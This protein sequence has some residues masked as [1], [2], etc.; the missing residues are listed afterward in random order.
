MIRRPPRST[1]TDTLFPYTTLFRSDPDLSAEPADHDYPWLRIATPEGCQQSQG[2][3]EVRGEHSALDHHV[4][5]RWRRL[6]PFDPGV[7]ESTQFVDAC[8]IDLETGRPCRPAEIGR[9]R[10]RG[11]VWQYVWSM[12]GPM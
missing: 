11:R 9:A 8:R 10:C 2:L 3:D 4:D 5:A 7:H 6:E 12:V 1:R